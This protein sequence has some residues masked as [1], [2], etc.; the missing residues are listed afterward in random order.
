MHHRHQLRHA[1]LLLAVTLLAEPPTLLACGTV[2]G[3]IL[4]KS[5]VGTRPISG[6]LLQPNFAVVDGPIINDPAAVDPA[7][8]HLWWV[9]KF[10]VWQDIKCLFGTSTRGFKTIAMPIGGPGEP[11]NACACGLT[12]Q[13]GAVL[14]AVTM[15]NSNP[16]GPV[17]DAAAWAAA[18]PPSTGMGAFRAPT[19]AELASV[20]G[21]QGG[22]AQTMVSPGPYT[23]N[24]SFFDVFVLVETPDDQDA[25]SF[26]TLG[27]IGL[28]GLDNAGGSGAIA[29]PEADPNDFCTQGERQILIYS[30]D[31]P[32]AVQPT[33]WSGIKAIY[34][35]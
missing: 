28:Y 24:S 13:P 11:M 12:L 30:P 8:G 19:A 6:R 15:R 29:H 26:P 2:N 35:H 10:T 4:P 14:Q 31:G 25:S 23:I 3:C 34:Q 7:T 22:L 16:S 18:N 1:A 5:C 17:C 27:T 33:T 9:L 20:Q 21:Y 32:V